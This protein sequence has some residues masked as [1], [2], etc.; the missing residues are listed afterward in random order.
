MVTRMANSRI[1][2]RNPSGLPDRTAHDAMTNIMREHEQQQEEA[3]QRVN[4]LIKTL[5][6][7]IDLAGCELLA[8]IELRDKKTGRA[9]R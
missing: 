2:Y 4:T 8:R 7:T 9:Y 1:P 5:K 3:D 6:A